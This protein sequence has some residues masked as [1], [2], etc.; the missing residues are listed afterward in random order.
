M[1]FNEK[2]D[3]KD[4]IIFFPTRQSRAKKSNK[5]KAQLRLEPRENL[6]LNTPQP[7][8]N[9]LLQ[10]SAN[11]KH[12]SPQ[13]GA[14]KLMNVR[15]RYHCTSSLGM[16]P[17]ITEGF[18]TKRLIKNRAQEVAQL[19]RYRP[20][21]NRE[22]RKK[23]LKKYS[24]LSRLFNC[25]SKNKLIQILGGLGREIR[26]LIK[27]YLRRHFLFHLHLRQIKDISGLMKNRQMIYEAVD[28]PEILLTN[29]TFSNNLIKNFCKGFVNFVIMFY[30][31]MKV[32][33]SFPECEVQM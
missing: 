12:D 28:S 1:Q 4:N 26:V 8:S 33:Y 5:I 10:V 16:A 14:H 17:V 32:R 30:E 25:K 29:C 24:G 27:V 20:I 22:K 21:M 2:T 11:P 15:I 31:D 13:R 6:A 18:S 3:Q 9:R 19:K 23:L 7:H